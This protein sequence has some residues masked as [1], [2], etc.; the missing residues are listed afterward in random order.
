MLRIHDV[1]L[2]TLRLIAPLIGAVA[3]ARERLTVCGAAAGQV[4]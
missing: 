3:Q 1:M 2:D 4:K